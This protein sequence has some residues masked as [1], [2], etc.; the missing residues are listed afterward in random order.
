MSSGV[1]R[2]AGR[3]RR[4][5]EPESGNAPKTR[6]SV[7]VGILEYTRPPTAP[8]DLREAR[9]ARLYTELNDTHF[10]RKLPIVPVLMGIPEDSVDHEDMNGLTRLAFLPGERTPRFAA[11][12]YIARWYFDAPGRVTLEDRWQM[13]ADTLLHE[14]VHLAVGLEDCRRRRVAEPGHGPRFTR[15][16]NRIGS[17]AGWGRVL[18]DGQGD[19]DLGDPMSSDWPTTAREGA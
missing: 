1:H 2:K 17:K 5:G 7:H 19:A 8:H 4:K 6:R 3:R 14:M 11:A 12:I 10:D 13:V 16:C 9:L 18:A 15:M